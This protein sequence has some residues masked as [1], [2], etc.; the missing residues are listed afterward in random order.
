M[1]GTHSTSNSVLSDFSAAHRVRRWEGGLLRF[2]TPPSSLAPA[3][4]SNTT[5]I[6]ASED[7]GMSSCDTTLAPSTNEMERSQTVFSCGLTC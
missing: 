5:G 6:Q 4:F 7:G 3:V 1:S 2:A